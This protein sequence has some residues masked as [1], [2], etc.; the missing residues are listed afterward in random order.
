MFVKVPFLQLQQVIDRLQHHICHVAA[1]I[2]IVFMETINQVQL[3]LVNK[4]VTSTGTTRHCLN[5]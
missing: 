5:R 2:G 4:M 1:S 3:R